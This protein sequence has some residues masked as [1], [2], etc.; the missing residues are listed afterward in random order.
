MLEKPMRGVGVVV[1]N[2][3]HLRQLTVDFGDLRSVRGRETR[4]QQLGDPRIT[5]VGAHWERFS[6]AF[7]ASG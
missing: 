1:Q 5:C 7:P 4:A 6:P 3:L 2:R